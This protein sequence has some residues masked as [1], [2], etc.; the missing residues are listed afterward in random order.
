MRGKGFEMP[1]ISR[2]PEKIEKPASLHFPPTP[3]YCRPA[4]M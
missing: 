4:K 2:P 3:D 1:L